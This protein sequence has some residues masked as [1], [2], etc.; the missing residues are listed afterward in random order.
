MILSL[1]AYQNSILDH[2]DLCSLKK[3]ISPNQNVYI[4]FRFNGVILFHLRN[5]EFVGGQNI[6]FLI[7]QSVDHG[8]YLVPFFLF[9]QTRRM[10][11]TFKRSASFRPIFLKTEIKVR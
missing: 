1:E 10:A 3:N 5:E 8:V 7:S 4:K 6:V 11:E 2:L 9:R